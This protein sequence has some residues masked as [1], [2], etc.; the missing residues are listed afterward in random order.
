MVEMNQG[1]IL[2]PFF[3]FFVYSSYDYMSQQLCKHVSAHFTL[4]GQ[5][6][7]RS[8]LVLKIQVYLFLWRGL[9]A[10]GIEMHTY[11][12]QAENNQTDKCGHSKKE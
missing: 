12:I 9:T 3:F 7:L 8:M 6:T 2:F 1:E 4:Q 11:H 10:L 5:H